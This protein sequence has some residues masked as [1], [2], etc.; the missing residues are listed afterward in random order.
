MS[1]LLKAA[2]APVPPLRFT[3]ECWAEITETE[4]A[5]NAKAVEVVFKTLCEDG[6]QVHDE[7]DRFTLNLTDGRELF[8]YSHLEKAFEQAAKMLPKHL[9]LQCAQAVLRDGMR[10]AVRDDDYVSPRNKGDWSQE[11][12]RRAVIRAVIE[13]P[14]FSNP[15]LKKAAERITK[16]YSLEPPL[17][18]D[19]LRMLLKRYELDW[20]ELKKWQPGRK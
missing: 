11:K 12:L 18:A 2:R 15:T 5:P 19:A 3:V 6:Q 8:L 9:A 10:V 1:K 14:K 4:T 16:R 7:E 13:V 17:T 20:W